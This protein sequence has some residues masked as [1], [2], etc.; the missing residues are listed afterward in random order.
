LGGLEV[1]EGVA[2]ESTD[3]IEPYMLWHPQGDNRTC[4]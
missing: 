4:Q 2:N 1:A 3:S